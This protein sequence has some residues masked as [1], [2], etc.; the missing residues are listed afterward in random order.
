MQQK[1]RFT[2]FSTDFNDNAFWKKVKK[3]AAVAGKQLIEKV[4]VLY[5]CL[6]DNDTPARAKAVIIGALGYFIV[7]LDAIADFTPVI[8]FSDD[9]GAITAA[10]GMVAAYV[11]PEHIK[12][13]K[14]KLALWF[15]EESDR[16]VS[17]HSTKGSLSQP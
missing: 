13:A 14:E 10:L 4:L 8:G 16:T 15:E 12:K 11:K 6:R 17:K 5:Y 1:E 9:L 2:D 3:F 7:P